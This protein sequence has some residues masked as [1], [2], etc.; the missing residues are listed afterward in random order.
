[1]W[2]AV[3]MVY[4]SGSIPVYAWSERGKPWISN[5]ASPCNV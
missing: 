3:V 4:F 5:P 2:K 1:M